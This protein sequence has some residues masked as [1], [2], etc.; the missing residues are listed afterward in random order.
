MDCRQC[1]W[2]LCQSCRPHM[3]AR[4]VQIFEQM[5]QELFRLHDLNSNGFLEEDE[6][7]QLNTK[8]AMLHHGKDVDLSAVKAKYRTLFREKLDPGGR[9][10][11]YSIF[12][13][14]VIEVLDGLDPDPRAQEMVLEQFAA[15][16]RSA[17]AV[18]HAPSFASTTDMTF[19]SQQ[20]IQSNM[21][22]RNSGASVTSFV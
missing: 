12:R 7:V 17:R 20:S 22:T 4:S 16:A 21:D 15:E 3:D 11:P 13:R 6:L 1:N 9:P 8:V 19:M 2:Y 18:F 14:Y 5:I 10:V